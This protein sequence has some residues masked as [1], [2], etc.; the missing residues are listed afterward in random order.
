MEDEID[1]KIKEME[2][3]RPDYQ[4]IDEVIEEFKKI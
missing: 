3:K 1:E 4:T 2:W